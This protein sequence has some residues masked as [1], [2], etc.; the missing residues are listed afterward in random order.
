MWSSPTSSTLRVLSFTGMELDRLTAYALRHNERV[1]AYMV[2]WILLNERL[3]FFCFTLISDFLHIVIS[4]EL[5]GRMELLQSHSASSILEIPSFTDSKLTR[6]HY[7]SLS[8]A[9]AHCR[10]ILF[11]FLVGHCRAIHEPHLYTPMTWHYTHVVFDCTNCLVF[12]NWV[13]YTNN[14]APCGFFFLSNSVWLKSI[15]IS[16]SKHLSH[17][18]PNWRQLSSS[19]FF[20]YLSL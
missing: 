19:S 4:L 3:S 13:I 14:M 11:Y 20:A 6:S 1:Y 2:L 7:L 5:H 17:H 9:R 15:K 16:K 10:A 18:W 8:R 12:L